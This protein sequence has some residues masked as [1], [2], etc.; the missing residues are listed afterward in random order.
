MFQDPKTTLVKT[1]PLPCHK[2][3]ILISCSRPLTC[4]QAQKRRKD[5]KS[6][7]HQNAKDGWTVGCHQRAFSYHLSTSPN[8]QYFL[9]MQNLSCC[10][11]VVF[12]W[13]C[14]QNCGF[15]KAQL[16]PWRTA[17]PLP[18]PA[19]CAVLPPSAL[20]NH[21]SRESKRDARRRIFSWYVVGQNVS[22]S[23][24]IKTV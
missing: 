3:A 10:I 24:H 5:C 9:R 8:K 23:C 15:S 18:G 17:V 20:R 4:G 6:C 19:P 7:Y 13:I 16:W 11:L 1:T 12:L 21:L 2:N 22:D 14:L